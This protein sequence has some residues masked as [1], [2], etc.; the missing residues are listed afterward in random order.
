MDPKFTMTDPPPRG[1]SVKRILTWAFVQTRE[2]GR[3]TSTTLASRIAQEIA[4][5]S[6]NPMRRLAFTLHRTL[7]G[8]TIEF[9]ESFPEV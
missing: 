8:E 3:Y 4:Y 6:I 2:F 7:M 9:S 5:W 1:S